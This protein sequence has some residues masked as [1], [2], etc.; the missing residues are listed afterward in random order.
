MKKDPRGSYDYRVDKENEVLICKWNDNSVVSIC[1]NAVGIEPIG[2]ASRYS[3]ST[4]GRVQ[5]TQPHL[6]KIYNTHMGGVDRMDQNISKYRIG[7]QGKKW[8]SPLV[9]YLIDISLNNAWH[10]HKKCAE[11]NAMDFLAF[12]RSVVR[13]YLE[14]YCNPPTQGKKRKSSLYYGAIG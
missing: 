13:F 11:N 5:I 14:R 6:F 1:S 9:T 8:Y 4:K 3:S 10:L 7:I 2:Q 12:R